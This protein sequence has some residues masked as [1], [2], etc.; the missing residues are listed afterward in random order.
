MAKRRTIGENPLDAAAPENPLDAVV[1]D[2]AARER[3][4][5]PQPL[6]EDQS[7]KI[8]ALEAEIKSLKAEIA[9]LQAELQRAKAPSAE[10]WW[11]AQLRQKLAD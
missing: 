6:A 5:T 3:A 8:A 4:G 10:P 11:M 1:P 2:L 9:L 7:A